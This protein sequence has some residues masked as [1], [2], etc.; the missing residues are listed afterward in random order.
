MPITEETAADRLREPG[1]RKWQMSLTV[2]PLTKALER[3]EIKGEV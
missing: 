3:L 2:H 1:V